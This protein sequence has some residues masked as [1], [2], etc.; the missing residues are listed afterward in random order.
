MFNGKEYFDEGDISNKQM[1]IE[2]YAKNT[3][4]HKSR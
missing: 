3:F 4:N 1:N 2:R